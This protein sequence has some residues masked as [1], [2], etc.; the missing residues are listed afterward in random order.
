MKTKTKSI[1]IHSI[2]EKVFSYMDNLG[3]TGMHMMENSAMM[4]GSK[5]QLQQ[6]SENATGLNSKFRWSGIMMGFAMDFTVIV[7]KWVKDKEKIWETV[8]EAKM[9]ILKWYQMRLVISP[10]GQNTKVVLS[11]AYSVPD[12]IIS[13]FIAFFLGPLYANWCLKKM[14]EDSKNYLENN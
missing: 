9:I 14:L 4:M 7:T 12:N 1:I 2:P 13:R 3:N 5:L 8:S 10:E 6:L 11:I